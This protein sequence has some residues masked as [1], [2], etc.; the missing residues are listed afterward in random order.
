MHGDLA[1][2]GPVLLGYFH[3]NV[4][5]ELIR[6]NFE[7]CS[8]VIVVWYIDIFWPHENDAVGPNEDGE[9]VERIFTLHPL[10]TRDGF[11]RVEEGGP[12][13]LGNVEFGFV[14]VEDWADE[15]GVSEHAVLSAVPYAFCLPA[16][17]EG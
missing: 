3:R 1:R 12:S 4:P 16:T 15:K 5:G 14:L 10:G 11:S 17:L 13:A 8:V 9:V 7:L 2:K 6:A